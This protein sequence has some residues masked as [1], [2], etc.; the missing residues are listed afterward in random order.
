MHAYGS[1]VTAKLAA[2]HLALGGIGIGGF[3]IHLFIWHAIW[4]LLFY[5][6][7]IH[8]FGPFLFFALIA[9]FI[10]YGIWRRQ[11]GPRR[12]RGGSVGYGTGAGPRDW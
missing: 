2:S 11:Y 9:V 8:T 6:W 10:G 3:L 7:H 12:R 5:V 4:R 1:A